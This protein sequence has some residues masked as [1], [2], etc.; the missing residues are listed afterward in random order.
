MYKDMYDKRTVEVV[1]L[2]AKIDSKQEKILQLENKLLMG[3]F[4]YMYI[5]TCIILHVHTIQYIYSQTSRVPDTLG[6]V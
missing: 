2:K 1:Q 3:T 4:M 5:T 6:P